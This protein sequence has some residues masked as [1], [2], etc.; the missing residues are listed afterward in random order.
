MAVGHVDPLVRIRVRR[1][2]MLRHALRLL[3]QLILGDGK[4]RGGRLVAAIGKRRS[5]PHR[6]SRGTR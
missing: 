1:Y 3:R 6:Q 5:N 2:L 4:G